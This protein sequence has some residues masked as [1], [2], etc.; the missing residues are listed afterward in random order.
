MQNE[1]LEIGRD[2][3]KYEYPTP[4]IDPDTMR[5]RCGEIYLQWSIIQMNKAVNKLILLRIFTIH[6]K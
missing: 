3:Q 2:R 6:V 4:T 1:E 5:L